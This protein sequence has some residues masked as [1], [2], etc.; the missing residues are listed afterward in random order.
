[1]ATVA[2][3][4]PADSL[5][6]RLFA[7]RK[8]TLDLVAPLSDADAAIQPFPDASPAKWHIAHTTWFFET[9]VLRDHAPEYRPFDERW[10][11]LFNSYYEAEGERHAR[12]KRGMVFERRTE[13]REKRAQEI[14]ATPEAED[15][16][17]FPMAIPMIAGPGS[18]ASAM[19][20]VSRADT[21]PQVLIVLGAITAVMLLTAVTLLAAGPLM[22]LIGEKVEAMIT[23]I[24]GV[25]LAALA[26]QFIVDGLKQSFPHL[27]A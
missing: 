3:P 11:F 17:V 2:R 24:L 13:R 4:Q 22:R 12:P 7:T 27:L 15:I 14:E 25:I 5:A 1:M 19:L 23:R 20:W 10:A 21:A 16:S 18:I 8:L 9:F 6:Q 26:T